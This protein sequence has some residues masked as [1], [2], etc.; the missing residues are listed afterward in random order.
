MGGWGA[1][2]RPLSQAGT[3]VIFLA[4]SLILYCLLPYYP[5]AMAL[6]LALVPAALGYRWPAA[7]LSLMLL[8]AAPAYSYQLGGEPWAAY[9]AVGTAAV[10][11]LCV[12]WLPG[13]LIGCLAGVV[14]GTLML[15]PY[16][17]LSLPL[18][19]GV[20]LVRPRGAAI[21]GLV[22]VSVFL[23]LYMPFLFLQQ[24]PASP[25]ETVPLFAQV[26]YAQ[27]PRLDHIGPDALRAALRGQ[28]DSGV[29]A[30]T[31]FSPYF[32][33]GWSGFAL[34]IAMLGAFVAI[35]SALGLSRLTRG[36]S[37]AL[38]GLT[39]LLSPLTAGLV[40]L[41]PLLLLR[42]P[43]GYHTGF[44]EWESIVALAGVVLVLGGVALAAEICLHRRSWRSGLT[45]SLSVLLL[46]LREPL[47]VT[48]ERLQQ[49]ASVCHKVDLEDEKSSLSQCEEQVAL[50]TE[51]L[52]VMR[53]R[54]MHMRRNELLSIRSR[55][56]NLQLGIESKLFR[57]LDDCGNDFK[58][59]VDGARELGV[60]DSPQ[61]ARMVSFAHNDHDFD[62]ALAAQRRL[63]GVFE[64]LAGRLVKAGDMVAA[65]VKAEF[66]PELS[67]PT[68][69]ISHGFLDRGQ[70]DEAARI[71]LEDLR[72]ADGRTENHIAGLA[73]R[74]I[75]TADRLREIIDTR[76][77]A[78]SELIGDSQ[79]IARCYGAVGELEAAISSVRGSRTL[80]DLVGIVL[81]S[82][83]IA[84]VAMSVVR[85]LANEINN[86][87]ADNDRRCPARYGREA[88]GD[89][90]RDVQELL[91]SIESAL[92]AESI[93]ARLTAVEQSLHT[94]EEQAEA[95][96][97]HSLTNE[98][99][100]NFPIMEHIIDERLRFSQA[101]ESAQLPADAKHALEY[102]LMYAA[103]N[104][105]DITV[106]PRTGT[107]KRKPV[108]KI[109][110][111]AT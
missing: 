34:V 24:A 20:T 69:D 108:R 14:A 68:I 106:D 32:V 95:V 38:R 101:V 10:S 39:P 78:M 3:S 19:A 62:S 28:T 61:A 4:A 85:E 88:S 111:E 17:Y 8:F 29:A 47:N 6:L 66:D 99:L 45:G 84:D 102:L 9:A 110:R 90:L 12:R 54:A 48:R 44:D 11:P 15:T 30:T 91:A 5:I 67:L 105:S 63:N 27:Q 55:L 109:G 65:I 100:M 97:Q 93:G 98:F 96:K 52:G 89:A 26:D 35:P 57:H 80:A 75:G 82:H 76:L 59:A 25:G 79:S 22:A 13:A 46:E 37:V 64:E 83:R 70:F 81:E 18:L 2:R 72:I 21:G 104:Y 87:K 7:A 74:T 73:D 60:M 23:A 51:S 16:F 92:S 50:A 56:L 43:L 36:S 94:I 31:G 107:F 86:I 77:V 42:G 71:I 1:L 41:V 49:V 53:P 58:H 40:F 103:K 33:E